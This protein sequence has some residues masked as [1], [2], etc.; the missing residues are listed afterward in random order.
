[1]QFPQA[2]LTADAILD[3]MYPV[4]IVV[5]LAVAD[6]PAVLFGI[7]TWV[8]DSPGRV[9]VCRDPGQAEFDALGETGG[10]KT[11]THA[12]GSLATSAHSGAAVADHASHTHD[13]ASQLTTPD[14]FTSN[15]G[16]TGVSGRSGG[17][18]AALTHNV[19]QPANHTMSGDTAADSTLMPYVVRNKWRRTA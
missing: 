2:N 4:G 18:S 9:T 8:I 11:H 3:R 16:G 5:E 1:M 10:A 6:D 14:L 13:V 19:T 17:P 7:G 12:A 15:T